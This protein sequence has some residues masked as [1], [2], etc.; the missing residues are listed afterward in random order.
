MIKSLTI[1]QLHFRFCHSVRRA[2]AFQHG[3][4]WPSRIARSV[5]EELLVAAGG[6]RNRAASR[7]GAWQS[8]NPE[9]YKYLVHNA[10]DSE[11]AVN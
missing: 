7:K 5:V 10:G 4:L 3:L 6:Q 11:L 8:A 1:L 2:L 9:A